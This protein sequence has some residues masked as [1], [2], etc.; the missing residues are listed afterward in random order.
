M[1]TLRPLLLGVVALALLSISVSAGS[2]PLVSS[3]GEA[4]LVLEG[5]DR[6]A[7]FKRAVK[8]ALVDA[9]KKEAALLVDNPEDLEVFEGE[10]EEKV[11]D[12]VVKYEV[13]EA[14]FLLHE[15]GEGES[16]DGIGE[17]GEWKVKVKAYIDT[18]LLQRSIIK[19]PV[20]G[21]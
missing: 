2:I 12:F 15:E 17:Y 1:S 19:S 4:R 13:M 3:V 9:V 5:S 10:I 18:D 7:A 16:R 14:T 6:A 21:G 8:E 20:E 11:R